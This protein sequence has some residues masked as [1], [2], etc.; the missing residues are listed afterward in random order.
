MQAY[1]EKFAF[2]AIFAA[3]IFVGAAT[4]WLLT[5]NS[6]A[7]AGGGS[8]GLSKTLTTV[9]FTVTST[10]KSADTTVSSTVSA[11]TASQ[12]TKAVEASVSQPAAQPLTNV[13]ATTTSTAQQLVKSTVHTATSTAVSTVHRVLK[14][15]SRTASTVTGTL[16]TVAPLL[17]NDPILPTLPTSP[18]VPTLPLAG[19]PSTP[20]DPLGGAAGATQWLSATQTFGQRASASRA[21]VSDSGTERTARPT[22]PQR[23]QP[24]PTP[25]GNVPSDGVGGAASQASTRPISGPRFDILLLLA[26]FTL[27]AGKANHF[28][29]ANARKGISLP[30]QLPSG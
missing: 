20:R 4:L 19:Q 11:T 27:L 5:A 6:A 28:R 14:G 16:D 3:A 8:L 9:S 24:L 18:V 29:Y 12:A 25:P 15:A 2:K 7:A 30:C 17:P 1:L 13:L 26:I 10:T 22:T 21:S 23:P